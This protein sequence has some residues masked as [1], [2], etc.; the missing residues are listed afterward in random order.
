M[1]SGLMATERIRP[2]CSSSLFFFLSFLFSWC[3]LLAA[4]NTFG[5]SAH[6]PNPF[7]LSVPSAYSFSRSLSLATELWLRSGCRRNAFGFSATSPSFCFCSLSFSLSLPT[8][9]LCLSRF[10]F[11]LLLF[12][13]LAF[14]SD[15]RLHGGLK[16]AGFRRNTFGRICSLL[17]PF[18]S[19]VSLG[20]SHCVA[21]AS[22]RMA[23]SERAFE[24]I[25]LVSLLPL[26]FVLFRGLFCLLFLFVA[27]TSD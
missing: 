19:P 18:S 1:E 17:F 22:D 14:T 5:F 12:L 15:C 3:R 25:H 8:V 23:A 21:L 11:R 27:F 16:A 13:F 10:H 4:R 20:S 24:G 7:S 26:L 9:A 2:L 6:S